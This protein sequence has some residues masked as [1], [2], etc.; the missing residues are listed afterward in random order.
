MYVCMCVLAHVLVCMP[1]C[2]H[3]HVCLLVC[4]YVCLCVCVCVCMSVCCREPQ[5]V[6]ACCTPVPPL[7][8]Q[9]LTEVHQLVVDAL[10]V[11][12]V[13]NVSQ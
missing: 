9:H 3:V 2:V 12:Y 5:G 4:A 11:P 6:L 7:L 8:Q 13:A 10:K 1:E